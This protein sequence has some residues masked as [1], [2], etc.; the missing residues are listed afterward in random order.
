MACDL[1]NF[2]RLV[3][4]SSA[5]SATALLNAA[6]KSSGVAS[7]KTV[8]CSFGSWLIGE[9]SPLRPYS[10]GFPP[11]RNTLW[12]ER[13]TDVAIDRL[14]MSILGAGGEVV[15]ARTAASIRPR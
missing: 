11:T 8:R 4:Q 9:T 1:K 2:P 15:L 12:I 5:P 13:G 6:Q 3:V 14:G 7:R 10:G